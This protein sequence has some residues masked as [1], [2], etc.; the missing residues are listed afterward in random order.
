MR[1][2]SILLNGITRCVSPMMISR[3]PQAKLSSGEKP[4]L[5]DRPRPSGALCIVLATGVA[6]APVFCPKIRARRVTSSQGMEPP[7]NPGRF[8]I[9]NP[10]KWLP[11][12]GRWLWVDQAQMGI[13]SCI[14][15]RRSWSERGY[16]GP[17]QPKKIGQANATAA[18]MVNQATLPII[19][20]MRMPLSRRNVQ[21]RAFQSAKLRKPNRAACDFPCPRSGSLRTEVMRNRRLLPTRT[22]A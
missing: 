13:T 4:P 2:G 21:L 8:T 10:A 11:E 9:A 15:G 12:P 1:R 19:T 6:A 22:L 18:K 16:C 14:S 20:P 3:H 17:I 7:A 5:D